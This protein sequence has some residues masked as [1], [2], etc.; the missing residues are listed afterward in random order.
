LLTA[1]ATRSHKLVA[2]AADAVAH[3][4]LERQIDEDSNDEIG[5]LAAAFNSMT[6]DL[7]RTLQVSSQRKALAAVGEFAAQLAHEVRNPLTSLRLDLQRLDER[8]PAD[9]DLHH[10]MR[11]VLSA[12]DRLNRTVTG[13]LRL[14]RS[15]SVVLEWL[16]LSAALEPAIEAAMPEFVARGVSLHRDATDLSAVQLRGDAD[17][18][19]QLFLNILLN[20]AQ[21]ADGAGTV[22]VSA[23]QQNSEV[24]VSIADSG[25]GISPEVLRQLEESSWTTKP[26]GTGLGLRIARRIAAAHGGRIEL[27]NGR[28]RGTI[29][30][31]VLARTESVYHA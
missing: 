8:L 16:P 25:P 30:R 28:Q 2:A 11:R 15:G 10:R 12:I 23:S 18:L 3:G 4:D 22:S 31:I 20:A 14:A 27:T 24:T 6:R 7:R 19:S 26:G 29:A 5:S 13:S 9:E 1:R 21:A 17:A